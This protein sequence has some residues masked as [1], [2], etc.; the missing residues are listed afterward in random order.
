MGSRPA[1]RSRAVSFPQNSIASSH[2]TASTGWSSPL[3]SLGLLPITAVH[4]PCVTSVR[5][6]QKGCVSFTRVTGLSSNSLPLPGF[7]WCVNFSR[8]A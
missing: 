2:D 5:P 7:G 3:N 8:A 6:S 1:A 4:C